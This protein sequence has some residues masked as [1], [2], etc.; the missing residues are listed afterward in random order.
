MGKRVVKKSSSSSANKGLF[1]LLR[2]K[3]R[4]ETPVQQ[5][6]PDFLK[7][8]DTGIHSRDVE[9]ELRLWLS[10][11]RVIRTIEE[12]Y[13]AVKN[14]KNSVY[15]EHVSKSRNEFADW[16]G[17]ILGQEKL[18]HELAKAASRK[19]SANILKMFVEK[20]KSI[21][22][23]PE[24]E[25]LLEE[26]ELP[27]PKDLEEALMPKEQLKNAAPETDEVKVEEMRLLEEEAAL[28][29][30]EE[31]LNSK[32]LDVSRKR[33]A[34]I[35]KRGEFE[36]RKFQAF[37]TS[38]NNNSLPAPIKPAKEQPVNKSAGKEQISMMISQAHEMAKSGR[39]N[40]AM[41]VFNHIKTSM[42]RSLLSDAEKRKVEYDLL[43]LEA[44]IRLAAL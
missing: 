22:L 9:P 23:I 8:I 24:A 42:N 33:Y 4:E 26:K 27:M 14:M 35:K 40:E 31:E 30:E 6:E 38:Y 16:V 21:R 13:N 34:L 20:S 19:E 5:E 15:N 25:K 29:K 44:E 32:R 43:G 41:G 1:K 39:V 28:N 2:S 10:D 37:L 12:L 36:R 18:A 7:E 11:G 17:E 3:A